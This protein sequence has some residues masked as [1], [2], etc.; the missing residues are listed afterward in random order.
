MK[1][2]ATVNAE[3][4]INEH[5]VMAKHTLAAIANITLKTEIVFGFICALAS[6]DAIFMAKRL[7]RV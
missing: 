6:A 1:N 3:D 5:V 2:M 4:A 7:L